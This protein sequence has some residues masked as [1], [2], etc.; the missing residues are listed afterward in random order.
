MAS[1]RSQIDTA[2]WLRRLVRPAMADIRGTRPTVADGKPELDKSEKMT[3]RRPRRES[4]FGSR[5]HSRWIPRR[6]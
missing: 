1:I 3:A 4:L 6:R 5:R 2:G